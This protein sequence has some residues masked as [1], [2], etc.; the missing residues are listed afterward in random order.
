M[1]GGTATLV[2]EASI[3][4][5]SGDDE[6]MFGSIR[7]IAVHDGR[8]YVLD[9][10]VPAVRVYDLAGEHLQD[11]GAEGEGPGEFRVPLSMVVG[12]DGRVHVRDGEL[13]RIT[14]FSP[15]G[16]TV[17]TIPLR[18]GFRST[19]QMVMTND[20]TLYNYERLA[21][22]DADTEDRRS[23]MVPHFGD[24]GR[25]GEPIPPPDFD[26]ESWQITGRAEGLSMTYGVPFAPAVRWTL[27][28]SGA[29][30]AGLSTDYH[31]EIRYPDGRLVHVMKSWTPVP[32]SSAEAAWRKKQST[33]L[34]RRNLPEWTWN[35]PEIPAAKPA[36]TRFVADHSGR[37]W[38]IRPGPSR[39]VDGDCD[40]NPEP[41]PGFGEPCWTQTTIWEI[42]GEDGRFLGTAEV[43]E[44][45]QVSPPPYIRDELFVA[46]S[47]DEASTPM[48]KR[49][50]LVLP[51]ER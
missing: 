3:G 35:G 1:W 17:D 27:A 16:D 29:V 12:A 43:P 37:I 11:I 40:E 4:V 10:Q 31:F 45:T 18:V 21:Q 34:M 24:E 2:E 9:N 23:G 7:S 47:L 51:G 48:V 6:Y 25:V 19:Y 39:H 36:Y 13:G 26:F 22:D 41:G 5:E 32:V 44:G 50:R 46:W 33:A 14:I 8:M 49:Y 30:V 38:V 28:P 20:G 42:F 15:E